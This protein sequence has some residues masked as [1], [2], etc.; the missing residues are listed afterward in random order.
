MTGS[1]FV[2]NEKTVTRRLDKITNEAKKLD[3]DEIIS[4]AEKKASERQE[5]G[6]KF[7]LSD[8]NR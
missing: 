8:L 6:N 4:S 7:E 3:L 5:T 2:A 1:S